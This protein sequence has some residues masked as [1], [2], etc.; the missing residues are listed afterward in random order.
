MGR[1]GW[2][3]RAEG[4]LERQPSHQKEP[5]LAG[6]GS[7]WMV[8]TAAAGELLG[9][10]DGKLLVLKANFLGT[11]AA[12]PFPPR[13]DLGRSFS[14]GRGKAAAEPLIGHF[15]SIQRGPAGLGGQKVLF[16]EVLWM[17]QRVQEFWLV[18]LLMLQVEVLLLQTG[19]QILQNHQNWRT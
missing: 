16:G 18:T 2:M 19:R 15:C 14:D 13:T 5:F 11:P 12:S 9:S 4:G 17:G 10:K 7:W 1:E 8:K 6:L 3:K